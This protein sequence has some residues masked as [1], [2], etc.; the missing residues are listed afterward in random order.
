M[1]D[2]LV[3]GA[4]PAGLM[5]AEEL[6]RAGQKVVVVDA[7]P[8]V[9]RKFL[10]AGK[11]GLNL[12]KDESF[13]PLLARY[14]KASGPLRN[15]IAEFDAAAVQTW[16]QD[17]GQEVFTGSSG[18]VFPKVM[19]T[20]PLLRAWLVR[21]A[22]LGV[23]FRT[24]WRWIGWNDAFEFNTPDGVQMITPKVCVLALGGASWAR[25]GSDG[26]WAE[27]LAAKGVDL[28]PFKPAN[29]GFCVDWT[30][31]MAKHFG[32]PVK[33]VILTAGAKTVRGEF[34]ISKQGIEGSGIYAVS[35]AMRNGAPLTIDLMPDW[36]VQKIQ[37]RLSNPRGKATVMNHMRKGLKLGPAKLALLQEFARPLPSAPADLAKLIKALPIK[38]NGP[39]PIDEAISTAGGVAFSGLT[40]GLELK[41]APSVFCAGEMLDWEAP[42][43][44]YLITACLA[45]G[46]WAGRAAGQ[47]AGRAAA[48]DC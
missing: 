6:A 2:A 36:H 35:K 45:T 30:P 42:T 9:G 37:S 10:M 13:E 27:M 32:A 22:E 38:H 31:F 48:K 43:G 18:Q 17:L 21:L 26:A 40:E 25:L 41:A 14:G 24:R 28:A 33:P 20:S 11:S 46:R 47:A 15:I 1:V 16:A 12:T 8:S 39:R 3:I 34:V 44:G 23:E 19:K 5:A 7:K 29:M 4:G